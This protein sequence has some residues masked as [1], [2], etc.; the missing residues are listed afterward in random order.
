[1]EGIQSYSDRKA[2]PKEDKWLVQVIGQQLVD[3]ISFIKSL[4][5]FTSNPKFAM[6]RSHLDL[7]P[8]S[9]NKSEVNSIDDL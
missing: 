5:P 9:Q 4:N 1:L 7:P 2:P 6:L 8:S 3:K